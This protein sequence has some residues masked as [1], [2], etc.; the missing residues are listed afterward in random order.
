MQFSR[1]RMA[2]GQLSKAAEY[3]SL[4]HKEPP[5]QVSSI[6]EKKRGQETPFGKTLNICRQIA[7]YSLAVFGLIVLLREAFGLY[8][9]REQKRESETKT[10][11]GIEVEAEVG[12]CE[13]GHSVSEALSMGCKYDLLAAAWLPP[14]CIDTSLSAEFDRS[15]PNPDGSWSYYS[16]RHGTETLTYE[17]ISAMADN[18]SAVYFTTQE[19]H[20]V[21]CNFYW[22]KLLRSKWMG[23]VMEQRYDS[24]MHIRHCG[25]EARGRKTPLGA[26]VTSQGASLSS[27][28]LRTMPRPGG[29]MAVAEG[30]Y[31]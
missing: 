8:H 1:W 20:I 10:E 31:R 16:S 12:D 14:V 19:W 26:I 23:V 3:Q 30:E 9:L 17:Q 15:G 13:C 22:L 24:E 11:T 27:K 7:L 6:H 2:T 4:P 25:I 18:V 28:A 5:F 29:M 21:H